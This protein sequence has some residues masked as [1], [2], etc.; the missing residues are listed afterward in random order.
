MSARPNLY[1]CTVVNNDNYGIWAW[2]TNPHVFNT[3]IYGN[4]ENGSNKDWTGNM[5]TASTAEF[6]NNAVTESGSRHTTGDYPTVVL[7]ADDSAFADIDGL[8]VIGYSGTEAQ[9]FANDNGFAFIAVS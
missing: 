9:R 1:N 6:L 3:V 5:P 7:L 4:T 2:N 8:C